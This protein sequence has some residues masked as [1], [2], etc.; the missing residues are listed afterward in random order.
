MNLMVG[1]VVDEFS[2]TSIQEGMRVPETAVLEFQEQWMQ[3]D[4]EGTHFIPAT[5]LPRLLTRMLQ[6]PLGVDIHN[7]PHGPAVAILHRLQDAWLPVR[8]G[9]IHFHETIFALA[10][11]AAGQRLPECALRDQL[12]KEMR[13]KLDLRHLKDVTVKW[14]AH[15]YFAAEVCQ[16]TYRGFRA[17]NILSNQRQKQIKR[18]RSEFAY[19][20]SSSI[21][22]AFVQASAAETQGT[23]MQLNAQRLPR[24]PRT[25]TSCA[26][27]GVTASSNDS[28]PSS[29]KAPEWLRSPP[30]SRRG[31]GMP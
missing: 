3:L 27:G 19:H 2:S 16:R 18:D 5:N 26:T 23:L 13:R 14:V 20:V 25:G 9:K 24:L 31:A 21:L 7:T 10:R 4:P 8:D 17:R 6:P 29:A 1:V 30:G 28:D 22:T 12:D 15:E 11:C